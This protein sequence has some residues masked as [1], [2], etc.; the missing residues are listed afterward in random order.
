MTGWMQNFE[1]LKAFIGQNPGIELS[2][3]TICIPSDVRA[4][5]YRLFDSVRLSIIRD[6]FPGLLEKGQLLSREWNLTARQA[7]DSLKIKAIEMDP[8]TN[9]FLQDPADGLTRLLFDPVFEVIR[10]KIDFAV[11]E[12]SIPNYLGVGIAKFLHDGYH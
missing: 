6:M 4:E 7:I 11:F 1:D 3:S 12:Q 2:P 5:F 8:G 9:W 10:G